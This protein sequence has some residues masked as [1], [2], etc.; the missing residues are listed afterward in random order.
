VSETI[1]GP[2]SVPN[3]V[4]FFRSLFLT[5]AMWIL[6]MVFSAESGCKS[7][8]MGDEGKGPSSSESQGLCGLP[9]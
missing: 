7:V 6:R 5:W 3:G 8:T 2:Q 9:K 1:S 4:Y